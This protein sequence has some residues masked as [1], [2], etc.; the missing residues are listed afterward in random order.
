MYK[1]EIIDDHKACTLG[2]QNLLNATSTKFQVKKVWHTA[3]DFLLSLK[4]K[5][6][7][8]PDLVLI[9]YRMPGL[10]GYHLSYLLQRDYPHIKKIGFSSEAKPKWIEHF[11]ATGCKGFIDKSADHLE[12]NRA[13][14]TVLKN[15]FYYNLY[16][17]EKLVKGIL[18]KSTMF[19]FPYG[20]I[21]NEYLLI[22]L[23]QTGLSRESIADIL[24]VKLDTLKKKLSNIYAMFG[25]KTH[26]ELVRVAIEKEI[27]KFY[28]F[29][30]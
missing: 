11:I 29:G 18:T 27:I 25:A 22:Q 28:N 6:T 14:E 16:V 5:N 12:L 19:E 3:H 10:L 17:N 8:E 13:I 4:R 7:T 21:D 23:C 1:V 15:E 20:L 24:N 30:N 2:L 26:S 9:D